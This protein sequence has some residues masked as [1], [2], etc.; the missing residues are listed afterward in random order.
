M[1]FSS[2]ASFSAGVALSISGIATLRVVKDRTM[3]TIALIPFIFG[4][5]QISEGF[6]WLALSNPAKMAWQRLPVDVFLFFSH[7]LWPV[8]MPFAIWR[9]EKNG[10][11]RKKLFSL[12]CI[13]C[14]L[15][16][17]HL[18]FIINN[19]PKEEILNC[20]IDYTM[21]F[22]GRLMIL[23]TILYGITTILPSLISTRKRMWLLGVMLTIS[24][25][26]SWV[27]YSQ[28]MISV[29]CF[30]AALLSGVVYYILRAAKS[31]RT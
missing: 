11:R 4:L 26:I 20:H 1:C 30:F 2:T 24:Y 19:I 6:V 18:F 17:Y 23:T 16:F 21:G 29:F 15:G 28:Y 9:A 7:I 27:F 8:W 5:Q 14:M 25:L 31:Q 10:D 12:F 13:G 22:P 3:L